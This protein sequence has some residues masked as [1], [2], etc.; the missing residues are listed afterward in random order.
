MKKPSITSLA[1]TAAIDALLDALETLTLRDWM[2]VHKRMKRLSNPQ[3]KKLTQFMVDLGMETN[4][5]RGLTKTQEDRL[6]NEYR[7]QNERARAISTRLPTRA[8]GDREFA[9][10]ME[11]AILRRMAALGQREQLEQSATGRRALEHVTGLFEGLLPAT[12]DEAGDPLAADTATGLYTLAGA[13]ALH[14]TAKDHPVSPTYAALVAIWDRIE[15]HLQT[16]ADER[17]LT[18]GERLFHELFLHLDGE[19]QNG[20]LR[21]YLENSAGDQGE[22]ARAYLAEIGAW[23]TLAVLDDISAIFPGGVIPRSRARRT[24]VLEAADAAAGD[25]GD[26]LGDADYRYGKVQGELYKR[27]VDYVEAHQADFARPGAKAINR[28]SEV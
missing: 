17:R 26:P 2:T 12:A 13:L 18:H 5:W 7:R 23:P 28:F 10:K 24:A 9:D 14:R 4:P 22:H 15:S 20:G 11:F 1:N 6:H 8:G 3:W 25:F 21:Q 16:P 27:L 19:Y